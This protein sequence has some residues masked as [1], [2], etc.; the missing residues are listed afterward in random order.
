M[1]AFLLIFAANAALAD[2][3]VSARY[4][5]CIEA[6]DDDIEAGRRIA[7]DWAISGGGAEA[8]HC[9]ALAD[10]RAGYPKLAAARLEEIAE[11]AD[12]GDDFIRARILS[13]AAEAWLQA[14]NVANAEAALEAAIE[15]AP[16]APE[17]Q[18]TAAKVYAAG[19]KWQAVFDAITAAEQ[20]GVLSS[21]GYVL[22]ARSRYQFGAFQEAA[23]DVVR[24]LA[25]NPRNIDALVLRGEIQQT[26]IEIEVAS[27]TAKP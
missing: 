27:G 3:P 24:A 13:Q 9:L 18:F 19:G 17:L 4:A 11:R 16:D 5:Q 15:L 7:Q 10:L 25:L 23:E 26:G 14:D 2:T 1:F 22:R 6:L 12:A 20:A 8:R 21:E